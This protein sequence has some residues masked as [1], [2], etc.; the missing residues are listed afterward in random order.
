M[1]TR[2]GVIRIMTVPIVSNR[3]GVPFG[4]RTFALLRE[5]QLCEGSA[6]L[7][8]QLPGLANERKCN[9]GLRICESAALF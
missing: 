9:F 2:F 1:H 4:F 3:R 6:K 7:L 5:L 8:F